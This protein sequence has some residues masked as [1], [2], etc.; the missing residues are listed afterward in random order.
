MRGGT[1]LACV[2]ASLVAAGCS[3]L[4]LVRQSYSIDPPPKQSLPALDGVV[5]AMSRVEVEPPFAGLSLVYRTG[6]HDLV[7][8]PYASFAEPPGW[9]IGAAIRGYLANADFVRDV[10]TPGHGLRP[11]ATV[12]VAVGTLAGELRPGGASAVLA[13]RFRVLASPGGAREPSEVL[14]KAY[15]SSR[16]I[17]R[18]TA[19]RVV[20]AWNEGL[21]DIMTEF[22]AD[23]SA[24]LAVL[25]GMPPPPGAAR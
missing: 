17:A 18:A 10:V 25:R 24:S 15:C 7:H 2:L 20:A 13:M 1:G 21:A 19:K 12:E 14:V 11:D 23:L 8:D 5:L 22:A 16:P 4:V 6:E 9:L 3:R